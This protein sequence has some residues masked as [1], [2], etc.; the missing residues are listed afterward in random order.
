VCSQPAMVAEASSRRPVL[1]GGNVVVVDRELTQLGDGR[2]LA[3]IGASGLTAAGDPMFD[4]LARLACSVVP[5]P[6]ASVSL[7]EPHWQIFP[8]AAG[9]PEPWQQQRQTSLL[10]SFCQLVVATA[11][12]LVVTDAR[13]DDRVIGNRA[14]AELNVLAYAG[15][16]LTDSEANVLGSLAVIDFQPRRWADAELALLADVA[17]ACSDSLRLRIATRDAREQEHAARLN[18]Q[19]ADTAFDRSQLLLR[20]SVALAGSATVTDIAS[21]VQDLVTGSL[22]PAHVEVSLVDRSDRIREE[23]D[24]ALPSA[25]A[26]WR[27]HPNTART[28]SALAVSTGAPVLL[29]DLSAVVAVAP[30]TLETFMES[31]WQATASVPLP[32]PAGPVGALTFAWKQPYTLDDA[33]QAVLAALGGYV[34]QAVHRARRLD[35]REKV[36]ALLQQAMLT[37][38]PD[39]SPLELAACYAP[40]ARGERVGGDWYDAIALDHGRV[41]LVVGD[42]TGHDIRAASRMGQLRSILRG[43][44]IDRI[45]PPAHLMRRLDHANRIFDKDVPTTAVL[46]FVQREPGA[47]T[48]LLQWAN[49]GHPH[50][51]LLTADGAV[52]S[53][54]GHDPL[55]GVIPGAPRT[56]HSFRLPAGSTLLLFTDGLIETRTEDTADRERLLQTVLAELAGIPL[57]DMVTEIRYRLTADS[58][59]DDVVIL[60]LRT[61]MGSEIPLPE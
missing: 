19:S 29:P 14:V 48:H 61:P 58:H 60:A 10:Y 16:P 38:L 18:Q 53:L 20:A 2:R 50:P 57:P 34:A 52:T 55:L 41:A 27:R 3:A 13:T 46:A 59:E 28:L 26:Q 12:P 1:R 7:V 4:R 24:P 21:A 25:G 43:Y 23:S 47:G 35:G 9:L 51:L 5:A 42:V 49:A 44:L 40:A 36:A 11:Q 32:G 17:A 39:V 33:E 54:A 45:E 37:D 8:G 56:T 6:G 31:G 30:E 22:G 15:V